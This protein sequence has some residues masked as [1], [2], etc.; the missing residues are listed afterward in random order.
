[1]AMEWP[2][3]AFANS[4]FPS[5]TT[6]PVMIIPKIANDVPAWHILDP[7]SNDSLKQQMLKLTQATL[8]LIDKMNLPETTTFDE[9]KG[10]V[11]IE[12]GAVIEPV[13]YTHLTL[14]TKRI[15]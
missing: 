5:L 14:P 9:S 13:S 10:P 6:S 2:S 12:A 3:N 7:E 11:M 1:M 8:D 15:V 4:L